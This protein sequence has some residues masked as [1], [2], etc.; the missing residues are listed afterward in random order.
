MAHED[1]VGLLDFGRR[2]TDGVEAGQAVEVGIEEEVQA[3]WRTR[4]VAVPN[5]SSVVSATA[6]SSDDRLGYLA[7]VADE[8]GRELDRLDRTRRPRLQGGPSTI[9]ITPSQKT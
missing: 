7:R 3:A 4:K 9:R 6:C 2:E 5:H 1:E 8:L